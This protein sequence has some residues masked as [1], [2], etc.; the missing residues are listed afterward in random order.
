MISGISRV[1][2]EDSDCARACVRVR[3]WWF[4][5][6]FH[7]KQIILRFIYS[8]STLSVSNSFV[9]LYILCFNLF[10]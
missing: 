8:V 2:L 3:A 7:D 10:D 1:V 5:K 4:G 9:N 6:R